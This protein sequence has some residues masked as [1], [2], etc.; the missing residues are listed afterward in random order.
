MINIE[1]GHATN[2][3]SLQQERGDICAVDGDECQIWEAMGSIVDSGDHER[4]K[5]PSRI[6]KLQ[7]RGRARFELVLCGDNWRKRTHNTLVTYK[8]ED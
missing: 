3:P 4:G 8:H 5:R 7:K 6:V 1:R 2:V